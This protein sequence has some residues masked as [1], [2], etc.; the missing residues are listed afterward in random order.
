VKADA[1]SLLVWV[2]E[3][4]ISIDWA[5]SVGDGSLAVLTDF[6]DD[7]GKAFARY[8]PGTVGTKT[9]EVTHGT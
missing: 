3:P 7:A 4:G 6:T 1:S 9:V 2:G 8:D 5:L